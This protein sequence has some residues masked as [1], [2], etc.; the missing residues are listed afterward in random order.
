MRQRRR[1]T[2]HLPECAIER[3]QLRKL[4]GLGLAAR[5][6]LKE[7]LLLSRHMSVGVQNGVRETDVLRNQQQRTNEP[8]HGP[9]DI[10]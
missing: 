6:G 7:F 10:R 5:I 4:W 2:Q 1:N 9:P 3:A 8:D